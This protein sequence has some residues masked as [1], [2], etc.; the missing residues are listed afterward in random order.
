MRQYDSYVG[1]RNKTGRKT[2]P[3]IEHTDGLLSLWGHKDAESG[4]KVAWLGPL[5]AMADGVTVCMPSRVG[6][7]SAQPS[8][9][10]MQ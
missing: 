10:A 7:C 6:L 9:V 1:W 4:I 8:A 3:F 5:G 2:G